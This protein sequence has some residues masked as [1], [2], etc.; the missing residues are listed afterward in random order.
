[1]TAVPKERI[2]KINRTHHTH[3]SGIRE[4]GRRRGRLTVQGILPRGESGLM[5]SALNVLEIEELV[6]LSTSRPSVTVD[7]LLALERLD[8]VPR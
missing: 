7:A 3:K 2:Q 6:A 1:M 8:A 5:A 4:I